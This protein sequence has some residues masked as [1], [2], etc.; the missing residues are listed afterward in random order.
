MQPDDEAWPSAPEA[1]AFRLG[2]FAL[3]RLRA[4]FVATRIAEF[5]ADGSYNFEGS[6][7]S[8]QEKSSGRMAETRPWTPRRRLWNSTAPS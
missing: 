8:A 7:R 5:F 1:D 6:K 2:V 3:V 4:A